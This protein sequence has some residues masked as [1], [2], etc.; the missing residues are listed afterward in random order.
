MEKYIQK[1]KHNSSKTICFS[2]KKLKKILNRFFFS[3]GKPTYILF[4]HLKMYLPFY[5]ISISKGLSFIGKKW[6][7]HIRLSTIIQNYQKNFIKCISFEKAS[8]D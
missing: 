2:I 3:I 1:K 5:H 8:L 6:H 4:K 7:K